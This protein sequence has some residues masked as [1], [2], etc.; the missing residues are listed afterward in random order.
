MACAV[1]TGA[2]SRARQGAGV[3]ENSVPG[4]SIAKSAMPFVNKVVVRT[5]EAPATHLV[6]RLRRTVGRAIP[7]AL[8]KVVVADE[9]GSVRAS[10]LG[11][12]LFGEAE[13]GAFDGGREELAIFALEENGFFCA[14][15][16]VAS[17]QTNRRDF[18]LEDGIFSA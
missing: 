7:S 8:P 12:S 18:A 5:L 14:V 17:D 10:G 1:G 9:K 2:V 11:G 3:W 15:G 13:E 6:V 4:T 16:D